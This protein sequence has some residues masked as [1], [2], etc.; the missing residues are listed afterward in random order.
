MAGCLAI[1]AKW[2]AAPSGASRQRRST[3]YALR[4][5]ACEVRIAA[6]PSLPTPPSLRFL[7]ARRYSRKLDRPRMGPPFAS[8]F[9]Y[10]ILRQSRTSCTET[11]AFTERVFLF[12]RLRP[13]K[14]FGASTYERQLRVSASIVIDRGELEKFEGTR[15][16]I[17][18]TFAAM[19]DRATFE[20]CR[21][22]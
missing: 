20:G 2:N 7:S 21:N 18:A 3:L 5:N 16:G 14:L 17:H 13:P 4:Y 11:P 9:A 6:G 10:N 12:A 8:L 15:F 19:E 22:K 1:Y